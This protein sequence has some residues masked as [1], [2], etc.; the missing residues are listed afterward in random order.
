MRNCLKELD[1]RKPLVLIGDLNV[2]HLDADIYNCK[3]KHI[4][5][6]AGLT[7]QERQAFGVM[8]KECN[9]VV[10]AHAAR[11]HPRAHPGAP[12]PQPA[13]EVAVLAVL[14]LPAGTPEPVPASP[15]I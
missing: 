7:P 11:A 12:D 1:A 10:R 6:Q 4:V 8:L 14:C 9:L 2:A 3:A 5:K 15:S 13:P